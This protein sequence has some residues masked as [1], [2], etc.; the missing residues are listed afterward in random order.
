M[1]LRPDDPRALKLKVP[2]EPRRVRD[3][4]QSD[5]DVMFLLLGALSLLV[6]AIGIANITLVGV[7]ERTQEIGIMKALGATSIDIWN[8]FLAESIIIG[9]IGGLGGIMIGMMGGFLFNYG[10]NLLAGA[11]GG[12][13]IDMFF[14][15]L[16]FI[17]LIIT[18]STIVGLI[19]G[20]YP[21]RRAAKISAL[22][23]VR[24]K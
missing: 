8:M 13:K 18:F 20:F 14:T 23:A 11:L 5:L 19:T 22:E 7:M 12:E 3:E 6:G 4:V 16:W 21:A 15:P 24:Y 9:F 2:M 17:L 10:I 1:A